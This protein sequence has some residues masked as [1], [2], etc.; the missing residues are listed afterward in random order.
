MPESE[1]IQNSKDPTD[2]NVSLIRGMW[3]G[4]VRPFNQTIIIIS[5]EFE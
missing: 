5:I 1:N 2:L 4:G 3:G